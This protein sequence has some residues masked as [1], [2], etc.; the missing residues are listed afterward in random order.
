MDELGRRMLGKR[1]RVSTAANSEQGRRFAGE[2]GRIQQVNTSTE[3][4][5]EYIVQFKGR[6]GVVLKPNEVEILD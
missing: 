3:G 4:I 6:E 2:V 5:L 1:A